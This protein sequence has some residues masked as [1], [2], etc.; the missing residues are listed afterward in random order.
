MGNLTTGPTG[1][2]ETEKQ[3]V[4]KEF[5]IVVVVTPRKLAQNTFFEDYYVAHKSQKCPQNVP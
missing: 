4:I 3:C 5:Q 2:I 1:V